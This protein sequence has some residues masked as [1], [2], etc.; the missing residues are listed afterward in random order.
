M[1]RYVREYVEVPDHASLDDVIALLSALRESLPPGADAEL[2][3]KGDDVF[4]RR[5][6]IS[7]MRPQTG[8][9]AAIDARYAAVAARPFAV[10]AEIGPQE[11]IEGDG[12]IAA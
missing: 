1:T 9:E 11:R 6:S 5:M 8:E 4:G 10:G 3:M 7:Y 12:C 2:R